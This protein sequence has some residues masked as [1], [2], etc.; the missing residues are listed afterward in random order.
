MA[1]RF[2]KSSQEVR[3]G[4][5]DTYQDLIRIFV[6]PF[7]GNE[8]FPPPSLFIYFCETAPLFTFYRFD[9]AV[10]LALYKHQSGRGG[11]PVFVAEKGGSL[12]EY[13]RQEMHAFIDLNGTAKQI[14]PQ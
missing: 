11:I 13:V 12:Y 14:Y 8:N 10:I 9:T 4:I 2:G 1:R 6:E 7:Q 5:L 3:A